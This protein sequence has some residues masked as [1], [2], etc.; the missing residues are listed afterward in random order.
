[1]EIRCQ[2]LILRD[3]IESDIDDY[4]RWFTTDTE[5]STW[6][7]SCEQQ[8][9]DP[10]SERRG[11]TEYYNAVKCM[12]EKAMRWKFEIE[13]S[14]KHI[15]WV[16]AY[17]IDEAYNY[18]TFADATDG[19]K[20]YRAVGI[21]IC[22]PNVWGNGLGTIALGEFIKYYFKFGFESIYIQTWSGNTRII[23]CAKKLGFTLCNCHKGKHELN[24]KKYD[25]LTFKRQNR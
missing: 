2:D 14:G 3:M 4:V 9:Y 18:I 12:P 20:I 17:L 23:R 22:E 7:A 15:G 16:S 8:E 1:M 13:H 19:Q 10:E 25:E 24:G 11:W 5:W 21:D 6:D